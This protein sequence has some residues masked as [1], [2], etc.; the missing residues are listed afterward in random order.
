MKIG[1]SY[2]GECK[3]LLHLEITPE[4]ERACL[5]LEWHGQRFLVDFGYENAIGKARELRKT[6]KPK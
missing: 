4:Q 5:Y 1:D 6:R 3:E 2:Y